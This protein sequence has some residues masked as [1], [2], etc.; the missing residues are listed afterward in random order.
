[1]FSIC[2]IITD[3]HP[4]WVFVNLWWDSAI[5]DSALWRWEQT[6]LLERT[7]STKPWMC[8]VLIRNRLFF[9]VCTRE[10]FDHE[11][12]PFLLAW[13]LL[14]SGRIWL[15]K[16]LLPLYLS[17]CLLPLSVI[18]LLLCQLL[19]ITPDLFI[20]SC[21]TPEHYH[22]WP[23]FRQV[24]PPSENASCLPLVPTDNISF[25]PASSFVLHFCPMVI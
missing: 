25:G 4:S 10:G 2:S 3:K 8:R 9:I 1:M 19:H 17:A 5:L 15:H 14:A 12:R 16:F 20:F 21:F 23:S 24:F 13:S 6:L 7:G 22:L 11:R 18:P